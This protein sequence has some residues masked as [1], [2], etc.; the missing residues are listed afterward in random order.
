MPVTA[1]G[2][3][4]NLSIIYHSN[5]RTGEIELLVDYES[6]PSAGLQSHLDQHFRKVQKLLERAGILTGSC[7]V[8]MRR[9]NA[10]YVYRVEKTAE[11]WDWILVNTP[12]ALEA[13]LEQHKVEAG[14]AAVTEPIEERST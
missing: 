11:T 1:S 7:V 12:Q 9:D 14:R 3:P 4:Y 5:W 10:E 8:R 13:P 2:Q 6:E